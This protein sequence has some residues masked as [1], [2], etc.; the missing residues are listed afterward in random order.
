MNRVLTKG[1]IIL[2]A[3]VLI[4]SCVG[5]AFGLY[6]IDSTTKVVSISAEV[7]VFTPDDIFLKGTFN[8]WNQSNDYKMT[9]SAGAYHLDDVTVLAGQEFKAHNVTT[10]AWTPSSGNMTMTSNG[11]YDFTFDGTTI[12]YTADCTLYAFKCP[13]NVAEASA[14]VF[15]WAWGGTNDGDQWIECTAATGDGD[16]SYYTMPMTTDHTGCN[17][18]RFRSDV[19]TPDW[20]MGG[21]QKWNQ[22]GNVTLGSGVIDTTGAW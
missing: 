8:G 7:E 21:E 15:A 18:V 12:T 22:S 9:Y 19:T 16:Y 17:L 14:K 6:W 11:V 3:A 1:I 10:D 5:S 13:G 4:A 20:S 2:A